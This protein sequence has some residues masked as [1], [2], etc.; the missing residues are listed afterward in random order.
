VQRPDGW[1]SA[2]AAARRGVV[3]TRPPP[4]AQEWARALALRGISPLVLPVLV[5]GAPPDPR[6][7]QQLWC[8]MAR[9]R[10]VMVVS[11]QAGRAFLALQPPGVTTMTGAGLADAIPAPREGEPPFFWW[12][13]G[14]GSRR[15]LIDAGVVEQRIRGPEADAMQSDSESLWQAVRHT[16]GC[17]DRVL[18]IRGGDESGEARGRT[19]LADQLRERGVAVDEYVA[20]VRQWPDLDDAVRAQ[21]APLLGLTH[22]GVQPTGGTQWWWFFTSSDAVRRVVALFP[23]TDWRWSRAVATH[24]RI[25]DVVRDA[26]FGVVRLS[27]PGL[28]A[29]LASIE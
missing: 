11:A 27:Q 13:T 25:A 10:A 18:I 22:E 6:R 16:I 15:A 7:G 12:V 19:W 14:G 20:Y 24:P 4:D 29:M 2:V 8:Q 17:A 1:V 26:G 21:V 28:D 3:I 5:F 9:Y 23:G